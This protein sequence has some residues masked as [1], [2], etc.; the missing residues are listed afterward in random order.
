MKYFLNEFIIYFFIYLKKIHK[1]CFSELYFIQKKWFIII[2][3]FYITMQIYKHLDCQIHSIYLWVKLWCT[4]YIWSIQ[5]TLCQYSQPIYCHWW[6]VMMAELSFSN[7]SLA[8][9]NLW[10]LKNVF[11]FH[12]FWDFHQYFILILKT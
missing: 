5:Q 6:E 7:T 10:E 4:T 9:S 3:K 1:D 11:D 8:F 12:Q 2:F